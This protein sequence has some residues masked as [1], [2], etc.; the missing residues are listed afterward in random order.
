MQAMPE[1]FIE[2]AFLKEAGGIH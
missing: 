1:C 2:K